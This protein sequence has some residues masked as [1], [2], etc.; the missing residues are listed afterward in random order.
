MVILFY[1]REVIDVMEEVVH[2]CLPSAELS[3]LRI[4]QKF[5]KPIFDFMAVMRMLK[6][7]IFRIRQK[8]YIEVV[9]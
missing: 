4:L 7:Q 1:Q 5:I 9:K 3:D 6:A 2:R 8:A